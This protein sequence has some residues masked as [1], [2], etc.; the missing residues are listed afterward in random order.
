MIAR[1]EMKVKGSFLYIPKQVNSMQSYNYIF[2]V[3][4]DNLTQILRTALL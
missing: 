1:S 3:L 2:G 4:A